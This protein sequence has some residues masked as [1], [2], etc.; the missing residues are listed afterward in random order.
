MEYQTIIN[1]LNNIPNPPSKI[2]TKNWVEISNDSRG[3]HSIK[4]RV[5]I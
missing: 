5:K 2:K 1:L 4:C 3:V